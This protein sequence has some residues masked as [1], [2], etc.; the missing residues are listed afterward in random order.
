LIVV[1]S[2]FSWGGSSHP[3]IFLLTYIAKGMKIKPVV[4][5][6]KFVRLEPMRIEHTDAL[7]ECAFDESLWQWTPTKVK[8]RSDLEDYINSALADQ[9]RGVSLPFVTIERESG[10]VAGSTRFGNIDIANRRA[11]IGWTWVAPT[12][13]RTG[14]NSEAKLLM[15]THAFEMW[16]CIR[17]ELKTDALNERSRTAIL[18]LGAKEEGIFRQHMITD[19]GRLRDT[20]YFSIIDKEWELIKQNLTARI[21]EES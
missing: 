6:G 3:P 9:E 12:R 20:V 10:K 7:S 18:R 1:G 2:Q 16:G 19:S 21:F 17:V 11:E 5:E 14:I 4:L 8:D 13:Q 15:L